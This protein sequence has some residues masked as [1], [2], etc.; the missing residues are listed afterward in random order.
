MKKN[1]KLFFALTLIFLNTEKSNAQFFFR[2][3]YNLALTNPHE[4]NRVIYIHNQINNTYYTSGNDLNEIKNLGGIHI[5]MGSEFDKNQG[6]E[7]SWSNRHH[8]SKSEFQYLGQT[9][10]RYLKVRTNNFSFGFYGGGNDISF[11]GSLDFGNCKGFYKRTDDTSKNAKFVSVFQNKQVFGGTVDDADHNMLLTTQLGF[12]P[13]VQIKEGPV[14]IRI[15]YHLQ[16]INLG[17]DNL[18]NKL[19]GGDI[20]QDNQLQDRL[21]NFGLL[22]FFQFGGYK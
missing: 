2:A 14:G 5:A 15:F 9:V 16:F 17:I 11:G 18:D 22:L 7:M 20:E 12:T 13:F 8:V 19:L 3:G 10:N 6:W 4:I 21:S 1:S